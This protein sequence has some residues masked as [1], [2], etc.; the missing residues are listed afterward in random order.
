MYKKPVLAVNLT[1]E[2]FREHQRL[3]VGCCCCVIGR[4]RVEESVV[5]KDVGG[6]RRYAEWIAG[7]SLTYV[8]P[9]AAV[10]ADTVTTPVAGY[11]D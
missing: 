2:V 3:V 1:G 5:R 11:C 4:A 10:G 6:Q 9:E 7:S 8:G